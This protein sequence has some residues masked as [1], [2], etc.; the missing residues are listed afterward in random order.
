MPSDLG[1]G[2]IYTGSISACSKEVSFDCLI[3]MHII[4]VTLLCISSE[5]KLDFFSQFCL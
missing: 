4:V 5:D 3:E 2:L 1:R